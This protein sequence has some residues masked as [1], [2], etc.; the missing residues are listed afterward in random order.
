MLTFLAQ[1][2]VFEL[3]IEGSSRASLVMTADAEFGPRM[4]AVVMRESDRL[5]SMI[6]II[7]QGLSSFSSADSS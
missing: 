3:G 4:V 2:E 7:W 1:Y 5:S 6:S